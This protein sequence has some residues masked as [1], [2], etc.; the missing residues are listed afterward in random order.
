MAMAMAMASAKQEYVGAVTLVHFS[1]DGSLLYVGMGST[2]YLYATQ[3]G[4]LVAEHA[5]MTRGILHGI[6][7]GASSILPMSRRLIH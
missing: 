1:L 4:D 2:L 3:T 5:I 7:F 6:D